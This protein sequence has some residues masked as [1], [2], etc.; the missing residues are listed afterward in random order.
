MSYDSAALATSDIKW[1]GVRPSD[2]DRYK[3]PDACRLDMTPADIAL[4]KQLLTEEFVTRN[5]AWVG[6]LELML[7]LGKKAE[8]QA[9]SAF[10]FQY[11]TQTY[12]PEK[13]KRGDWI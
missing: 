1:L 11:L 4:G 12:L 13:L 7:K 5:P 9:L 8:I 2:L 3:I 10:G 6:E